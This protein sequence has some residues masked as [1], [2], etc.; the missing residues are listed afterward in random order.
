MSDPLYLNGAVWDKRRGHLR[1][2]LNACGS[3]R[4]AIDSGRKSS[5]RHG[6][7]KRCAYPDCEDELYVRFIFRRTALGYPCNHFWLITEF[8]KILTEASP[9]NWNGGFMSKKWAVNFCVRFNISTQAKNNIKETDQ[10]D[11]LHAIQAFHQYLIMVLQMS[12]PQL[13]SKYGRFSPTRMFHVDQVP[14][15]FACDRGRTLNPRGAKSCRIAGVST[16]GL[17]KRHAT[18]QLWICAEPGNQVI[19]PTIIFRGGR[20]P[21]SKL[22]GLPRRPCS[23]P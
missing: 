22:R 20:G 5:R 9:A 21:K 13:D 23:I 6:A 8:K 7:V 15:P 17:E 18:V 11:R 10:V 19:K 2:W 14:L 12:A 4:H 1:K 16:S 3:I